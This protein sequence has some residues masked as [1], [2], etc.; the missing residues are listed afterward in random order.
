MVS[1]NAKMEINGIVTFSL[2]TMATTTTII[3][4]R[5]KEVNLSKLRIFQFAQ[6][7]GRIMVIELVDMGHTLV[8]LLE[9]MNIYRGIA[10]KGLFEILLGHNDKEGFLP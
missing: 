3:W 2:I 10:Q 9:I 8:F 1:S 6:G 5:K 7:V 4:E